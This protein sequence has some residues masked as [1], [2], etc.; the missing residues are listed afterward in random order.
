MSLQNTN[1][2]ISAAKL[3]PTFKGTPQEWLDEFT[4][5]LRILSPSGIITISTSD[6]E[7][8][9]NVGPWLKGG[10]Q[11]WVFD[12]ETKRYIPLDISASETRWYWI[13]PT[14]PEDTVPPLWLKTTATPTDASPVPGNAVSWYL[15]NGTAWVPFNSIPLS[16]PT[17]G[18]PASPQDFLQYFDTDISTL[19]HWERGQWRTVAGTPGDIKPVAFSTL[20]E[21]LTFNPG[22]SLLGVS[23]RT[24]RGRY[25]VQAAKDSG[26][27]PETV[28][29]TDPGVPQRAVLEVFGED[30]LI[31]ENASSDVAYPPT[32]AFWHLT[33]D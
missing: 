32:I 6:T 5:R 9:S 16:G 19:I 17:S 4:K 22:W 8:S 3:P 2:I 30:T 25:L 10:T 20:T 33:K 29:T 7:P 24:I 13:G 18:R 31:D 14:V 21:A 28:V 1:L 26:G 12:D 15:F 11:W 27:T 23:N